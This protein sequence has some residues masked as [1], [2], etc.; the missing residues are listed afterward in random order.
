M[1][2]MFSLLL[3]IIFLGTVSCPMLPMAM[4]KEVSV[5]HISTGTEM[6]MPTSQKQCCAKHKKEAYV[7][8]SVRIFS[9]GKIK[10][11]FPSLCISQLL[12]PFAQTQE[13]YNYLPPPSPRSQK[14]YER[15]PSVFLL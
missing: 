14:Y 5:Q 13:T 15:R 11:I 12:A 9:E 4:A 2:R 7:L 6:H 8:S 10:N 1:I 3:G